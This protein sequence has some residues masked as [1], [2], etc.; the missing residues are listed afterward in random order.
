M[1]WTYV[2]AFYFLRAFVETGGEAFGVL[3]KRSVA[4]RYWSV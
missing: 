3:L 2:C 1:G 4:W